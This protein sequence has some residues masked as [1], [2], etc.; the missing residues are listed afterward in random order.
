MS[1][2]YLLRWAE[3]AMVSPAP[4]TPD[5]ACQPEPDSNKARREAALVFLNG[6][7]ARL[8]CRDC[9]WECPAGAGLAILVPPTND[10]PSFRAAVKTLGL[11]RL[12]TI[13]RRVPLGFRPEVEHR[14][15]RVGDR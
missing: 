8:V 10:G 15:R 6:A 7:G 12:P 13:P 9:C 14:R 2:S 4:G 1:R 3:E 11:D 5:T